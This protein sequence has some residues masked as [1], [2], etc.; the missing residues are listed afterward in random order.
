M[1]ETTLDRTTLFGPAFHPL[2]GGAAA[3]AAASSDG[4]P[5]AING[6]ESNIGE[7]NDLQYACIFPLPAPRDCSS[8][9]PGCDCKVTD[10]PSNR[11]ICNGTT[12]THAKAY[13]SLRELEVL[14]RFGDLTGNA[15]PASICPKTISPA[16]PASG[17]GPAMTALV[18]RLKSVLP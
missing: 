8:G 5:N 13:P 14:K 9:A 10:V 3:L 18:E 1:V 2:L 17:Y 11:P 12:Q 16:N 15:I 6:H 4:Q 7:L